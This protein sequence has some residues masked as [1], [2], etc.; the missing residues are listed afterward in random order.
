MA[1]ILAQIKQILAHRW[2]QKKQ[3]LAANS[4]AGWKS[5]ADCAWCTQC[6]WERENDS[7]VW[8]GCMEHLAVRACQSCWLRT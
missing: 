6:P 7:S 2:G 4:F 8:E 3:S 1:S 5:F